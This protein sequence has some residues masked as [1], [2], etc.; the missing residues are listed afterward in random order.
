MNP[1]HSAA[2]PTTVAPRVASEPRLSKSSPASPKAIGKSSG[3]PLVPHG[4]PC[5]SVLQENDFPAPRL[6]IVRA[7]PFR[8]PDWKAMLLG[9]GASRGD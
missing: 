4:G 6:C 5:H 9:K 1:P 8:S 3:H 7:W 2:K